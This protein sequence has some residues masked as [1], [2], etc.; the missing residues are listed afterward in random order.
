MN[1]KELLI[2]S[3]GAFLTIIAWMIID[4][5]H[6]KTNTSFDTTA[7]PVVIPNYNVNTKVFNNLKEL[8]E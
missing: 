5:Y 3:I 6:V 1:Q 8:T 2:L 4:L 7:K